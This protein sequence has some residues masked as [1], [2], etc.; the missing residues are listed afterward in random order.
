M[1]CGL[2]KSRRWIFL[3]RRIHLIHL[4]DIWV[5]GALRWISI[6]FRKFPIPGAMMLFL[7]SNHDALRVG[8]I[9]TLGFRNSSNPSNSSESSSQYL[10]PWSGA[11]GQF[12]IQKIPDS[13][14]YVVV[15]VVKF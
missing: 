12:L 14:S 4:P 7:G 1:H 9:Q 3:F 11:V 2:G 5:P 6:C 10:G 15:F 8:K 13:C